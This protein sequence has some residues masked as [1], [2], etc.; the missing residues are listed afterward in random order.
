MMSN[1]QTQLQYEIIVNTHKTR[2]VKSNNIKRVDEYYAKLAE[3]QQNA[4]EIDGL[5]G[6][7]MTSTNTLTNDDDA[8]EDIDDFGE[9]DCDDE[10]FAGGEDSAV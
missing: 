7:D 3:E 4:G 10:A 2:L 6:T 8:F 1:K 5:T 9:F